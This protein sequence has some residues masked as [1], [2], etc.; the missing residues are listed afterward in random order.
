MKLYLGIRQTASH[1][2]LAALTSQG[3]AV[4]KTCF[5]SACPPQDLISSIKAIQQAFGTSIRISICL[6]DDYQKLLLEPIQKEFPSVRRFHSSIFHSTQDLIPDQDPYSPYD[7][8]RYPL[9]LAIL[10]S[11]DQ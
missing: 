8:Y 6:E 1:L 10:D 7:P 5:P 2:H 11:L 3:E 4:L 9:L